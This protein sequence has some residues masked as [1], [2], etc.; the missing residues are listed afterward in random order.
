MR[1]RIKS[2]LD[3][4]QVFPLTLRDEV[5]IALGHLNVLMSH[6]FHDGVDVHPVLGQPRGEGVAQSVGPDLVLVAGEATVEPASA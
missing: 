1:L 6:E 5:G 4:R 2:S 3:H